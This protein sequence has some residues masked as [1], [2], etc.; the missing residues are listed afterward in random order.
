MELL[1]GRG[2]DADL[3]AATW[4]MDTASYPFFVAEPY[5]QFHDG[6][7][8]TRLFRLGAIRAS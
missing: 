7:K 3:Q 2:N 4:V 1:A 8:V 5:H 6:F